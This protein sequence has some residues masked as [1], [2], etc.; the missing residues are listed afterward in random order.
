MYVPEQHNITVLTKT[1]YLHMLLGGPELP[2][3]TKAIM[4]YLLALHWLAEPSVDR[5]LGAGDALPGA[6]SA[7]R[8]AVNA[9]RDDNPPPCDDE[10]VR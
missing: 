10:A 5:C 6:E 8:S 7:P 4:L 2:H 9:G 1:T 3:G